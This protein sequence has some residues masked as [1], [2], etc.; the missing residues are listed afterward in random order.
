MSE[1]VDAKSSSVLAME[2]AWSML[3][4]LMGGTAAMRAA[5]VNYL[6]KWPNEDEASWLAR[7]DVATLFPAYRR[8][9]SVMGG[10]PFSKA[11]TYGDD[12]PLQIREWCENVD[13]EGVNLHTFASEMFPEAFYGLAGILV[14][15]P[16]PVQ[17]AG[18]VLTQEEANR[19]NVRPYMVRVYHGQILGWRTGMVGGARKLTMLRLKEDRTEADGSFGE[20]KVERVRVL[21]PGKYEVYRK[22]EKATSAGRAEWL[23]E[24]DGLT[25]LSEI[26]FVPIYG[27]RKGFMAGSAPLL[28]LGFL[29][30]KH[31]QSQSDQDTILHV[32]RLPILTLAGGDETTSLTLGGSTAV[33]LPLGAELKF[34]EHSG[35]GIGSG[36]ES[37]SALEDQMVQAGAELL[38]KKPGARSATESA[39]DAEA[40]KSDL[41]RMVEGFEDSLDQALQFMARYA[42]LPSGGH[43]SLYKD[44]GAAMLSDASAQLIRD[45]MLGGIISEETG[46]NELKRRGI[47]AADVTAE[48]EREKLS[49]QPPALGMLT[50]TADPVDEP[51]DDEEAA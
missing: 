37:L 42:G 17:S 23:V 30:V 38:I 47:L 22:S 11:L 36:Q 48:A 43:V 21:T 18:P 29:N 51:L 45:L 9:V 7:R 16:Q 35:K 25:A 8:T 50:A 26:P 24:S 12:V 33:M 40:N 3:E 14:E 32:A 46:I 34:V 31:W 49:A 44:F 15:A 28:D 13:L 20:K 41:Q 6:P 1:A 5:G 27:S 10:K 2:P 39:N 19:A 4:A